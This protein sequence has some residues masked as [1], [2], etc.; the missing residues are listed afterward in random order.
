[1]GD[2]SASACMLS[3]KLAEACSAPARLFAYV[4]VLNWRCLEPVLFAVSCMRVSACAT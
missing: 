1:M 3:G 4:F 2:G